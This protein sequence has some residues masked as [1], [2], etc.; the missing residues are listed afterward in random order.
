MSTY[1]FGELHHYPL[2]SIIAVN[3]N[4][5]KDI[6]V[7]LESLM[8]QSYRNFELII[9]DND[10]TDQS[11]SIAKN[12]K[13]KFKRMRILKLNQNFGFA[14]GNNKGLEESRGELIC[15][16]NIDTR[17]DENWLKT[18]V[19]DIS[20]H[21]NCAAVGSKTLFLQRFQDLTLSAEKDFCLSLEYLNSSLEYS[22]FF[23]IT[24]VREEKS[25]F[26]Q[27]GVIKL[28]IPIQNK[29]IHLK[30]RSEEPHGHVF[31]KIGKNK[32]VILGNLS[33]SESFFSLP[34]DLE[35]VTIA[36]HVINNAGGFTHQDLPADRGLGEFD[37][38]QY[39]TA[40]EVDY[41]CGVSMLI[42]RQVILNRPLFISEYFAYYE[43]AELSRWL[44]SRGHILRY[45]PSS[46]I[47]HRHSETL[48][49]G[50]QAWHFLTT[51]SQCIFE[52][53]GRPEEL[54]YRLKHIELHYK[55]HISPHLFKQTRTFTKS[56]IRRI[57]NSGSAVEKVQTI[58]IYNRYWNTKGGG[59]SHALSFA[60][61]LQKKMDIYLI[62]EEDFSIEELESYFSI[63]LSNCRKL[64]IPNFSSETTK[65]FDVFINSTF[66]SE[67]ISL[68]KKS[69]YIVFFPQKKIPKEVLTSYT[70]L[71]MNHYTKDWGIKYW[72]KDQ[73][74]HI[75]QPLGMLEV[76]NR[77][78]TLVD[79]QKVIL[80]VGRFFTEAHSKRQDLIAKVFSKMINEYPNATKGW[81]LVLLGS[82]DETR[83]NHVQYLNEIKQSLKG[84]NHF[85]ETN[86]SR[87]SLESWYQQSYAY[88]HAS[89]LQV[90]HNSHPEKIEHFGI[91]LFEAMQRGCY[92][93]VF[94][95]G[96]PYETIQDIGLGLSFET[97]EELSETMI[98]I[99]NS[100]NKGFDFRSQQAQKIANLVHHYIEKNHPKQ[101]MESLILS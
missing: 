71:Y 22:K 44:R 99:V 77:Q 97:E 49:E 90:D 7:F 32:K 3:H 85:I 66:Q 43:D 31:S 74:W 69:Y 55:P 84:I 33:E 11:I 79:K 45:V 27:A 15:T 54:Y 67:L 92:P 62:S 18:L 64:V 46:V 93:A 13:L 6:Y 50:S 53:K 96:G 23:I 40:Q 80:S 2:V 5:E 38:A 34:F 61:I 39:Q 86:A 30:I 101:N 21:P 76:I 73:L 17:L 28:R 63:D 100:Y 60:S 1:G 47:Y 8:E 83:P 25:L 88:L 68:S 87:L 89:G 95:A 78:G 35:S 94:K 37:H 81:K 75:V 24:G 42:R 65:S 52:F 82:L 56:L 9:V 58:G 26:S 16:V 98:N 41:L 48:K 20:Q 10:S 36:S 59:E 91:T 12:F 4:G 57:K 14:L 19:E 51:R 29:P 70:F 72:G